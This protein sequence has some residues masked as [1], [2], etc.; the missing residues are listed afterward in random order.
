[1]PSLSVDIRHYSAEPTTEIHHPRQIGIDVPRD[2]A[3]P[4]PLVV[5]YGNR[6]GIMH[7]PPFT[8][9]LQLKTRL[10]SL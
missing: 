2:V 3:K 9:K 8:L 1:M 4:T 10:D 6:L 7:V 5:A